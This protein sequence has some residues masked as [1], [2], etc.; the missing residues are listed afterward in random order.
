[1]SKF[2]GLLG[3]GK[4][5]VG[6]AWKGGIMP[7]GLIGAGMIASAKFL[8]FKTLAPNVD[9]NKWFMKHEGALKFG[10]VVITLAIW[11][12]CPEW[13]KFILWGVAAQG[14]VKEVRTLTMNAEGKSFFEAIGN[15]GY[16]KDIEEAAKSINSLSEQYQTGVSGQEQG[17]EGTNLK[18]EKNPVVSLSENSSTGVSGMGMGDMYSPYAA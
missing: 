15:G 7:V 6:A 17:V 5:I 3:K 4:G 11:K 8:D 1:M 13:I 18:L 10:G 12:K 14:F 9:P 16:D 2:A